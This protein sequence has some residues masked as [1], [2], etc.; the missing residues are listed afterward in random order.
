M[1]N[2][3]A[4]QNYVAK[5]FEIIIVD[6]GSDDRTAAFPAVSEAVELLWS[7]SKR[8]CWQ[9]RIVRS[10]L[11]GIRLGIPDETHI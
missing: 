7:I 4:A 10:H 3:Y 9:F 5:Q 1:L 8:C 11:E 2:L 6:D